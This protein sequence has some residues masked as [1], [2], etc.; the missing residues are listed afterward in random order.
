MKC[1]KECI[2]YYKNTKK[3]TLPPKCKD[4]FLN[5]MNTVTEAMHVIQSELYMCVC[6]E[7]GENSRKR[8]ETREREREMERN[9]S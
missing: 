8:N 7:S 5:E 9:G 6:M 4:E 3:D 1:K 2:Y